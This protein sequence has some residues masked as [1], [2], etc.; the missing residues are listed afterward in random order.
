MTLAEIKALETEAETYR[1]QFLRNGL[2]EYESQC[3]RSHAEA[4]AAKLSAWPAVVALLEE[5]R[6]YI[7]RHVQGDRDCGCVD[8]KVAYEILARIDGEMETK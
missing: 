7:E 2:Q 3:L 1:E 8:C 5:A 4:Q 6:D